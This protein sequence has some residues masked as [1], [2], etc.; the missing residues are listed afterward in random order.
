MI[1]ETSELGPEM[2]AQAAQALALS[3]AAFLK[4]GSGYFGP[5][6]VEDVSIL[7]DN[8]GGLG[9]KAA[10]GIKALD[11]ALALLE[12]GATRL[13]TSSGWSIY[14]EAQERWSQ[15]D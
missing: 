7:A 12:A 6:T 14:R 8:G 5:A 15:E 11:A 9:I 4:T 2:S 1:L 13:G 3:G 10:G